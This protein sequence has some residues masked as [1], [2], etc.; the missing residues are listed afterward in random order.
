[1]LGFE[2]EM[3]AIAK[4]SP[5]RE[6]VAPL[7]ISLLNVTLGS[8]IF[9]Q[10]LPPPGTEGGKWGSRT[11]APG[12]RPGGQTFTRGKPGG[13][14]RGAKNAPVHNPPGE[15]MSDNFSPGKN[16]GARARRTLAFT[17]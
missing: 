15:N 16:Q 2:V 13:Q 14:L 9:L 6:P 8:H 1:M 11:R 7:E 5:L 3:L 17:W 10:F 4:S 12:P